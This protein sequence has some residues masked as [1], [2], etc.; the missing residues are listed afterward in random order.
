MLIGIDLDNTLIDYSDALRAA[1]KAI[2]LPD[3]SER[4]TKT[5]IRNFLRKQNAGEETWQKLQG[6]VYGVYLK[7]HG[8]FYP[9]A[10]RFLWRCKQQGHTVK[11]ISHKTEFAHFSENKISLRHVAI[12]FLE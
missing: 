8:K 1:S 7:M 6:L 9:G 3:F 12:A 4:Y 5:A 2:G 10:Q 11:V